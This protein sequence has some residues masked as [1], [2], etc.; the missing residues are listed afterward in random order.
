VY[1]GLALVAVGLSPSTLPAVDP[2]GLFQ[3]AT[4]LPLLLFEGLL[5]GAVLL[6][7][8]CWCH[9]FCLLVLSYCY[10]FV[11]CHLCLLV[12]SCCSLFVGATSAC[13][14]CPDVLYLLV[15]PLFV[16]VVLI[17]ASIVRCLLIWCNPVYACNPNALNKA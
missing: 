10:L 2:K 8:I 17:Y 4:G 5:A 16:D 13:W 7:F 3:P 15:S 11:W 1:V 14:C 9:P 12:L 6:F